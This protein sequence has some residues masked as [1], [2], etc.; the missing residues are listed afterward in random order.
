MKVGV[1][2]FGGSG[3][4]LLYGQSTAVSFVSGHLTDKPAFCYVAQIWQRSSKQFSA[5]KISLLKTLSF[6]QGF[7]KRG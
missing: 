1:G 2:N 6:I 7:R 5:S 4:D 3:V